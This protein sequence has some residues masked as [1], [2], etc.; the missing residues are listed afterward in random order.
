VTHN[1]F[2][3]VPASPNWL[4]ESKKVSGTADAVDA[5]LIEIKQEIAEEQHENVYNINHGVDRNFDWGAWGR[6]GKLGK[7]L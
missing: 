5:K 3:F 4:A 7:K 2:R 6:G 1:L